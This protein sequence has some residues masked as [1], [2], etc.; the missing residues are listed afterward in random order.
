MLKAIVP[1]RSD[2]PLP[3]PWYTAPQRSATPEAAFSVL[4][5]RQ[6]DIVLERLDRIGREL[7]QIGRRLEVLEVLIPLARELGE[8]SRA[9]ASLAHAAMGRQGP[10]VRR[11]RGF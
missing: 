2:G 5:E 4:Q 1:G 10:N 3:A 8:L 9:T 11:E 7:E 6:F